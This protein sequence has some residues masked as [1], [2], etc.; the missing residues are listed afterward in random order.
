MHESHNLP[1]RLR[2][3]GYFFK[4]RQGLHILQACLNKVQVGHELIVLI[5]LVVRQ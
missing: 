4:L 5:L 3:G 2:Q 1:V